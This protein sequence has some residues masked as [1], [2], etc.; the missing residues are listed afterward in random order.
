V[1]A[2]GAPACVTAARALA[3]PAGWVAPLDRIVTFHVRDISLR[4]A[5]D[6]L[7]AAGRVRLSYSPESL[8]LDRAVCL[9]LDAVALG[10]VLARL[11]D[12]ASV[13]PVIAAADHVVLAAVRPDTTRETATP[14]VLDRIV[15]TGSAAGAAQRPLP[16][17]IDVAEG[18]DLAARSVGTV[19]QALNGAVPGI[20]LWEQAPS[21][22]VA[23]YGSIRGASSFGLTYPKVYIDGIEVANP[24]L[25]TRLTPEAIERV[26]VIR[27]PQGAALYGADAISG[28]TNIIT[29]LG[30]ADANGPRVR[31]E[32]GLGLSTSDF[33][34]G[35]AVGQRYLLALRSGSN[36]RSAGLTVAGES[37]GAFVPGAYARRLDA[38][39]SARSVGSRSIVTGTLRLYAAR[40]ASPLSPILTDSLAASGSS[41]HLIQPPQTQSVVEYTAGTTFKLVPDDRWTHTIVAGL[42]GYALSGVPDDRT[43]I[44]AAADSALR[45]ARGAATRGTLHLSSSV[46]VGFGARAST[47]LTLVAEQS[48]LRQ[49][50]AGQSAP[51]RQGEHENSYGSDV[52][53]WRSTSGV[54]V[55]A[56]TALLD[57]FFVS[58]GLRVEGATGA[59]AVTIP[60]VGGAWAATRG[61]VTLK[62]RAAYGDGVRWP[63]TTP[64]QAFVE[65]VRPG[66]SIAGLTPE[67][68]SGIEGGCDLIVGRA[69]TLQVTHFDQTAS[70]LIQWVSVPRDSSGPGPGGGGIGYEFQNV[71]EIG[72][73]GWEVQGS[74]AR[75]GL[76]LSGTVSLVDS[77]VRRLA[78]GYTGDLQPG[79]RMLQVP[80]RTMSLTAAWSGSRLSGSVT[81]Y[82]AEDWINYD[83]LALAQAFNADSEPSRTLVGPALRPY[84]LTYPGV[85]HLRATATWSLGPRL[86]LTLT[87]DNLLNRQTGEPDN[88]T[89]LPGRTV[90]LGLRAGL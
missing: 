41:L 15:V 45:A 18:R 22:L 90:S 31:L 7:A 39:G 71:G 40:A 67:R 68:Q 51:L 58:G 29:R 5:L 33:S 10:E 36:T 62:L 87:G 12:G 79:D 17:A 11:L 42:D 83:R 38:A 60:M 48:V 9:A 86:A 50:T 73:R 84:W 69:F 30:A 37:D 56:S 54:S 55:L 47:D 85:T 19:A 3:A 53:Q 24:L 57:R 81:A 78:T 26:E 75:G 76:S 43:P 89:V 21:N 49:S 88:V 4:E 23:G 59:G 25:L 27:G 28:V 6:R 2:S 34:P 1:A 16:V 64:R 20:W 70:G 13:M 65:G 44:P 66:T 61:R 14:I 77:R 82:R 80:A 46:R 8:P 32:S 35:E 63:Q 52:T 74:L 72:N